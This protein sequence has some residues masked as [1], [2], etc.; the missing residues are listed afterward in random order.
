MIE[1]AALQLN[2]PGTVLQ[3]TLPADDHA[4][5]WPYPPCL[6]MTSPSMPANKR[7]CLRNSKAKPCNV[8][9]TCPGNEHTEQ[10]L[11][12]SGARQMRH[13]WFAWTVSW[14]SELRKGSLNDK[15]EEQWNWGSRDDT[16]SSFER[17]LPA[18]QLLM[19]VLC[20][21]SR[22]SC[23][24]FQWNPQPWPQSIMNFLNSGIKSQ[25]TDLLSFY[26]M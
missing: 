25:C 16:S 6:Q 19:V 8:S 10:C 4:C 5:R 15:R 13:D 1:K 2:T 12:I 9:H 26:C 20:S 14:V 18:G 3:V 21:Q 23:G 7:L 17:A 24:R 11:M 22:P